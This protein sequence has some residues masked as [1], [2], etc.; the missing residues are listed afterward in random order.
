[1]AIVVN[2][3]KYP[4]LLELEY[5]ELQPKLKRLENDASL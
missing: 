2:E 3:G 5:I 4:Y 1:M